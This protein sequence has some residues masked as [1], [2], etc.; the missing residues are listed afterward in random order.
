MY[1]EINQNN[2]GYNG[3]GSAYNA[4]GGGGATD[5]RL[6]KGDELDIDS[7]LT[8]IIVAAGA[9]G[10]S[11]LESGYGGSGG[12]LHDGIDGKSLSTGLYYK[13]DGSS[14]NKGVGL[15]ASRS[16]IE[17]GYSKFKNIYNYDLVATIPE[18]ERGG[19]GLGGSVDFSNVNFDPDN[20]DE[21]SAAG[22]GG[23]GYFGGSAAHDVNA[24]GGGGISY[25]YTNIK[26]HGYPITDVVYNEYYDDN[27]FDNISAYIDDEGKWKNIRWITSST[28]VVDGE[29]LML[30]GLTFNGLD[31]VL[32][33][34][35]NGYAIIRKIGELGE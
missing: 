7:L 20:P 22:A 16:Q 25:V 34:D 26:T 18:S 10:N 9:G 3:G 14:I 27:V 24:G 1:S 21:G 19:F 13:L 28:D 12:N 17:V 31:E 11:K 5:V 23:S 6:L 35:G 15:G 32:G 30:N 29:S 4:Y 8:R 33:N 2:G